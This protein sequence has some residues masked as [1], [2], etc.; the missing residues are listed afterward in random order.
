M[1]K[2]NFPKMWTSL[3]SSDILLAKAKNATKPLSSVG[4]IKARFWGDDLDTVLTLGIFALSG[5]SHD[6]SL[7]NAIWQAKKFTNAP[8]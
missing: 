7:S 1:V 8:T 5:K 3:S 6:W 4:P 2:R